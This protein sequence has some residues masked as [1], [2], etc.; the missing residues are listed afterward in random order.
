MSSKDSFHSDQPPAVGEH[1]W[2]IRR[3]AGIVVGVVHTR[4][5][6]EMLVLFTPSI[7]AKEFDIDVSSHDVTPP[8]LAVIVYLSVTGLNTTVYVAPPSAVKALA[9]SSP[10]FR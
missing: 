5:V 7:R 2:R 9:S 10:K 4:P 1:Q 3:P 6:E 8:P